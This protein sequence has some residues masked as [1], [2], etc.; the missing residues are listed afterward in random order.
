MG[1][2]RVDVPAATPSNSTALIFVLSVLSMTDFH[3]WPVAIQVQ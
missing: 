2:M 1:T 3:A